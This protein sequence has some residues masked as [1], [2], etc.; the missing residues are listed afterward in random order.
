MIKIAILEDEDASAKRLTD[1]VNSYCGEH[2]IAVAIDRY[3]TAFKLLDHYRPIYDI[4]FMDIVLPS[5]N[6]IEAAKE[7]RKTDDA[8]TIV[9]VTDMANLAVRGYEVN[10]L[11]FIVKPVEYNSFARKFERA[12]NAVRN[13]TSI[14]VCIQTDRTLKRISALKIYY[15]EIIHHK[16]IYHT[17]EGDFVSRG[18]LD[19]LEKQLA[20]ENFVR[21]NACY[22]VN[23]RFIS[24]VAGDN[25][26]VA[27]ESLKI[28]R[29]KK[30]A[31]MQVLTNYLGKLV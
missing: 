26:I 8:V 9:F 2:N 6:G 15:I 29:T 22:L 3:D 17:E 12:L 25:V 27:G 18:T 16:L 5:M 28:S 21:C 23:M 10:A 7:L 20:P 31:F 14:D 11:D 19:E 4:I 24:E 13:R 1:A 30:K